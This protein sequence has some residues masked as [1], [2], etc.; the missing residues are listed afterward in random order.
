MLQKSSVYV[1]L[2]GALVSDTVK[3][4]KPHRRGDRTIARELSLRKAT[5]DDAEMIAAYFDDEVNASGDADFKKIGGK[6]QQDR[7]SEI[8]SWI[9]DSP[10]TLI[11]ELDKNVNGQLEFCALIS[12]QVL[13]I[14]AAPTVK[15]E[16]KSKKYLEVGRLIVHRDFRRMSIGSTLTAYVEVKTHE[17]LKSDATDEFD[18][19][20]MRV[21]KSNRSAHRMLRRLPV[22]RIIDTSED[23]L[24]RLHAWYSSF[25]KRGGHL[26]GGVVDDLMEVCDISTSSLAKRV[27]ASESHLRQILDGKKFPGR[28]MMIRMSNVLCDDEEERVRFAYA[29]ANSSVPR[30]LHF[31]TPLS[32]QSESDDG[33]R[34][35]RVNLWIASDDFLETIDPNALKTV[36]DAVENGFYRIYF[37]PYSRDHSTVKL[38]SKQLSTLPEEHRARIGMYQAPEEL[39]ALRVA[40]EGIDEENI[41]GFDSAKVSVAGPGGSRVNISDDSARKLIAKMISGRR[42]ADSNSDFDITGYRKIDLWGENT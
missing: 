12:V 37:T 5:I 24:D 10:A 21:Q 2:V 6:G 3:L 29:F 16:V 18:D 33:V 38:M 30:T 15:G 31:S 40:V 34:R 20:I 41:G 17:Y 8:R 25:V 23:R 26:F 36:R 22:N 39:C 35:Q 28:E 11:A 27:G 7:V 14:E 4:I 42:F 19:V 13:P 9:E 1:G 32:P